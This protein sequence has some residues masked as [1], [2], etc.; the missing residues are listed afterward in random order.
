[1]GAVG[2][3]IG[4]VVGIAGSASSSSAAKKAAKAQKEALEFQKQVYEEQKQEQLRQIAAQEEFMRKQYDLDAVARQQASEFKS[5]DNIN[6]KYIAQVN[7]QLARYQS[8]FQQTEEQRGAFRLAADAAIAD[9]LA[10]QQGLQQSQAAEVQT[11]QVFDQLLQQELAARQEADQRQAARSRVEGA[12]LGQNMGTL[13]ASDMALLER[14]LLEQQQ[15]QI[16]R[17]QQAQELQGSAAYELASV[18][19]QAALN[20][21]YA[22]LRNFGVIDYASWLDM[23]AKIEGNM[24]ER[25]IGAQ[26]NLTDLGFLA[27]ESARNMQDIID[28]Q[29]SALN[30]EFAEQSYAS[31]RQSVQLTTNAQIGALNA[32]KSAIQTP[33]VF[34]TLGGITQGAL[35]I[36]QGIQSLTQPSTGSG[37]GGFLSN[38]FGF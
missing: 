23:K 31:Q 3:I 15:G 1:M 26:S 11:T 24:R 8:G 2:S 14:D 5:W 28:E 27:A 10:R 16:Q 29:Q 30:R 25:Q 13:S 32:Q 37:S 36:A 34:S 7:E 20:E 4:G 35:G 38:L 22:N 12:L 19:T 9:Q 33:S 17:R 6:N 18:A 21:R